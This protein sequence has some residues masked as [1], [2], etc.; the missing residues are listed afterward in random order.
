VRPE[1]QRIRGV[2][3]D[4]YGTLVEEEDGELRSDQEI[5]RSYGYELTD[6]LFSQWID[7]VRSLEHLSFSTG[8]ETYTD[9]Q[10]RLWYEALQENGI[11]ENHVAAL[12]E[13]ASVRSRER[14]FKTY[15][16]AAY[17]LETIGNAGRRTAICSNWGWDLPEAVEACG[18]RGLVEPVVSSAHVGYRKPHTGI[19]DVVLDRLDLRADEVL[20]VGDTWSADIVGALS[21]GLWAAQVV[22]GDV[23][24]G[25]QTITTPGV[26][27]IADLAELLP[28]LQ[29]EARA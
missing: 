22:R 20:F 3:F 28:L 8:R 7:P 2:V 27:Q 13:H 1:S 17:V 26:V 6:D 5:F 15:P 12:V 4:F 19:F 14:R 18:L 21:S 29:H 23:V 11:A 25:D 10:R 9:W 24:V 16:D